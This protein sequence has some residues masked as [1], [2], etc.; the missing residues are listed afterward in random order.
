MVKQQKL[1]A[2]HKWLHKQK[3]Q[4]FDLNNVDVLSSFD[5]NAMVT[6]LAEERKNGMM[7]EHGNYNNGTK[8]LGMTLPL[9]KGNQKDWKSFLKKP[10]SVSRGGMM[11]SHISMSFWTWPRK[12]NPSKTCARGPNCPERNMRKTILRFH[13]GYK[14]PWQMAEPWSLWKDMMGTVGQAIKSY[15][16]ISE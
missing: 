13:N 9:F 2:F 12:A 3:A 1:Q 16:G 4:D 5:A 15:S 10:F 7:R 8:D 6:I 11:V 14:W